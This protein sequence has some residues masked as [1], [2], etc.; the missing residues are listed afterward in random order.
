MIL[1]MQGIYWGQGRGVEKGKGFCGETLAQ[2][3]SMHNYLICTTDVPY[4]VDSQTNC[5]D[6]Y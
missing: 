5:Q 6:P 3:G 1:L 4:I 2:K